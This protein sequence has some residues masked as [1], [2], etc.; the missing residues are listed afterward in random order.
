MGLKSLSLQMLPWCF[1]VA[2]DGDRDGCC[3]PHPDPDGSSS[4]L[5][6]IRLIGSDGRVQIYERPVSA[7]EVMK[8]FP[9]HLI[10][11]S[12]SFFIGQKVPP[13]S[14]EEELQ[15]GQSYFLLPNQFFHSV[16]S[17]VTVATSLV[18]I[19]KPK[20]QLDML[21]KK[22]MTMMRAPFDIHKTDKGML[23]IRI[24]EQVLMDM[25]MIQDD[26]DDD[27]IKEDEEINRSS[28]ITTL[29]ST[30]RVCNT[31]ELEKEY[32]QLGK[33]REWRPRLETI[34][35]LYGYESAGI[36]TK[37]RIRFGTVSQLFFFF[38]RRSKKQHRHY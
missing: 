38:F 27:N 22:R 25:M 21:K 14:G 31:K 33:K 16:L 2:G 6:P 29:Y 1:H 8:E 3:G 32:K 15:L 37:R 19:M 18:M 28:S 5:L 13:L 36:I 34:G 7:S 11:N 20:K 17:F 24:S 12:E 9:R 35:E 10:C 30:W 4:L 26:G 23:Q